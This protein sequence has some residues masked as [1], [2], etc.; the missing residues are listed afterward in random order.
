MY[1]AVLIWF[2]KRASGESNEPSIKEEGVGDRLELGVCSWTQILESNKAFTHL[3][4]I[5]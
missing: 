4:N 3:L 5:G 1:L 2:K